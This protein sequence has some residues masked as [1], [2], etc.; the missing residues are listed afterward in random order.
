MHLPSRVSTVLFDAGNTLGHLDLALI[1]DRIGRHW[2]PVAVAQVAVAEYA[3]KAAVDAWFRARSGGT[4]ATRQRGYFETLLET[5]G[6]P[7]PAIGRVVADLH[8]E[9]ARD[10]IWRVVAPDALE[11]LEGLSRRGYRMGVVSNADGR[12]AATLESLGLARYLEVIVDSH[13]VGVEKPQARIFELALEACGAPAAEAVFVGDLYEVDV[14]GARQAGI[15]PILYDPL[16]R[17]GEVDCPRIDRLSALLDLLPAVA[18]RSG[19]R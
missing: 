4:D 18:A 9:N 13:V 6:V 15:A 19:A 14:R 3:A 16:L 1:A 7:A 8:E 5:L 2:Q 17:Y 11:A 12:V 10:N